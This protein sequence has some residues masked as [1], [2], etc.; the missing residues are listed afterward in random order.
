MHDVQH[1]LATG[2][3]ERHVVGIIPAISFNTLSNYAKHLYR[4]PPDQ[5][6]AKYAWN[7][8]ERAQVSIAAIETEGEG[9]KAPLPGH[10][11]LATAAA[12][13]S[14]NVLLRTDLSDA[15]LG[16]RR[17]S[18]LAGVS[19]STSARQMG[20]WYLKAEFRWIEDAGR[21]TMHATPVPL[22]SL[23]DEFLIRPDGCHSHPRPPRSCDDQPIV[24]R[25]CDPALCTRC[26]AAE[27]PRDPS[28]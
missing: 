18:G 3:S 17:A 9:A 1:F 8:Q 7:G 5:S 2:Y 13:S 10:R 16:E 25:A 20:A 4:T 11:S 22:A 26:A 14:G 21:Y 28:I 24:R 6:F 27:S 23:V 15:D 19:A 12:E